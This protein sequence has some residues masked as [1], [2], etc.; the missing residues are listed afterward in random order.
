MNAFSVLLT[1]ASL[2]ILGPQVG[3]QEPAGDKP[4]PVYAK[5][6]HSNAIIVCDE[7]VADVGTIWAGP[8]IRHL[9]PIRNKGTETAWI[10]VYYSMV[11]THGTCTAAIDPG[12]TV[13]VIMNLDSRRMRER[14]EASASVYLV[15][16]PADHGPICYEP[17]GFSRCVQFE[18]D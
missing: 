6:P 17:S 8:K 15:D 14:F 16:P 9:F 5:H 2:Y 18:P 13:Y 7:P 11:G 4:A 3:Q 1:L 12:E 10:R